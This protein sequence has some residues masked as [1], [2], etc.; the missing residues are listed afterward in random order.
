MMGL[1]PVGRA[2]IGALKLNREEVC[3]L[4]AML[5]IIGE[6]PRQVYF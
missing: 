3:N 5:F 4:R 2:T 1:T 6:H